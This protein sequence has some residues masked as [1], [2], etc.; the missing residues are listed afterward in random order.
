MGA[1]FADASCYVPTTTNYL[2]TKLKNYGK[3]KEEWHLG[4]GAEDYHCGGIGHC[5]GAGGYGMRLTC[6]RKRPSWRVAFGVF[7]G[8]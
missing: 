5:G 3:G 2:N 4:I 8:G 1:V 7:L 6:E